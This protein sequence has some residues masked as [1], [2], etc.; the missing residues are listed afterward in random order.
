MPSKRAPAVAPGVR[1]TV[2]SESPMF[3]YRC[4]YL[5]LP[6][7]ETNWPTT[8]RDPFAEIAS[9]PMPGPVMVAP[10]VVFDTTCVSPVFRLRS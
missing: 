5:A 6:D 1:S 7:S 9:S 10:P 8:I 2:L 3:M 4:Q